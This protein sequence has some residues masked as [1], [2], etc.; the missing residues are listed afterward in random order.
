[1]GH[2]KFTCTQ[3]VIAGYTKV[4]LASSSS[5]SL[6]DDAFGAVIHHVILKKDE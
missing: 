2:I 4:L 6:S 1:L 5:F 3:L